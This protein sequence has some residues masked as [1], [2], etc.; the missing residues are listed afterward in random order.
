M[1]R[2]CT[3]IPAPTNLRRARAWD[4]RQRS[5]ADGAQRHGARFAR[6]AAIPKQ[7]IIRAAAE[8]ASARI[9]S[10]LAPSA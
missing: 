5:A 10:P 1:R 3:F 4:D 7:V 9:D 6:A 8:P 2:I